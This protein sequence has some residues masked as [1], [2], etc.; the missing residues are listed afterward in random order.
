MIM[1]ED[2]WDIFLEWNKGEKD[3][4]EEIYLIFWSWNNFF[5]EIFDV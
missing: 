4:L 2:I 3:R 1:S 5:L